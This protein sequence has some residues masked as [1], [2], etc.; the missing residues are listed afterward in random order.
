MQ[1]V[2]SKKGVL[3][4]AV[5]VFMLVWVLAIVGYTISIKDS[6]GI[7]IQESNVNLTFNSPSDIEPENEDF[8]ETIESEALTLIHPEGSFKDLT[9]DIPKDWRQEFTDGVNQ[10]LI[11][12]KGSVELEIVRGNI[13]GYECIAS[14]KSARQ[15]VF[16]LEYNQSEVEVMN[17]EI[18]EI[19]LI[20]N[21][22]TIE[23]EVSDYYVCTSA[24]SDKGDFDWTL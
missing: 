22:R 15:G 12:S 3:L 6:D 18:G 10:I 5:L 8:N 9:M 21:P 7:D 11:L 16:G 4:I 1:K 2:R 24:P 17:T 19:F 13:E 20:P 23:A 14:D